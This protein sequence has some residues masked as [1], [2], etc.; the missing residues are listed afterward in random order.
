MNEHKNY[1]AATRIVIKV[2]TSTL[3]YPNGRL[4]LQRIERLSW[5]L[6]DLRNQ[7][8]DVILVTSGAIGVGATRLGFDH[9]P[10]K[11]REKQASA[12]VGQAVLIQI[13]QQFFNN[14]NQKVAQVLLT[15]EDI[16]EG[17]RRENI[18]NPFEALLDMGVIPIVNAN[19]T[20]S[21]YEIE[22]SDN[23]QLSAE[24]ASLL[25]AE[26]LII[27]T[28]TDALYDKDPR[29]AGDARRIPRVTEITE[30]IR[31]MAGEKGSAFGTGGMCTKVCA[32]ERC[33]KDGIDMAIINGD[34]PVHI[35]S[36]L[37]GKDIGTIF[38]GRRI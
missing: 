13:Y 16:A 15:K 36:V 20:I 37:E 4:N 33:T 12:A 25:N 8:K 30:D 9:R 14:Y 1:L 19:D 6:A 29:T 17:R 22:F 3:T 23:D 35:H 26:L 38:T 27:L 18:I 31:R 21:T 2:G 28:D 32:A 11:M 24:V 7:G 10:E 5:V 34:D